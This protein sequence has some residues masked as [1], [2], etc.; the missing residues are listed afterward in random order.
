MYLDVVHDT[1]S[2]Q[3]PTLY[4][5]L[6]YNQAG[7]NLKCQNDQKWSFTHSKLIIKDFD[8][9]PLF[10][11]AW[12]SKCF[13]FLN[14]TLCLFLIVISETF[15]NL[16]TNFFCRW[17]ID[18]V[19]NGELTWHGYIYALALIMSKLLSTIFTVASSFSVNRLAMR[20]Q[21]ATIGAIFRKV[22]VHH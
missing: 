11:F 4:Y 2:V 7:A 12:R 10:H 5:G 8:S 17:F 14:V 16:W 22:C 21:S 3:I 1:N 13:L 15:L 19:R 6:Q 18:Y 20:V 9:G